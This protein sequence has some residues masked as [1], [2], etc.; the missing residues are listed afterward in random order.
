MKFLYK[1]EFNLFF[2]AIYYLQ[3]KSYSI[4]TYGSTFKI[5]I[6]GIS[7]NPDTK[8]YIMVLEDVYCSGNKKIDNIIQEMQLKIDNQTDLIYEW[9]PYNQFNDIT[10]RGKHIFATVYS[11]KWKDGPLEYNTNTKKYES[12]PNHE[13]LALIIYLHD[14]QYVANKF[15]KV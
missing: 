9:I 8:D 11:A 6:Y 12:N 4:N 13:A 14:S 1:F 2:N 7:Q 10:E 3:F 15:N 5:R